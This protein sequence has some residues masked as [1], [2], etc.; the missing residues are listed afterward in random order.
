MNLV[1]SMIFRSR[2]TTAKGFVVE[3][4][5][6]VVLALSNV[7]SASECEPSVSVCCSLFHG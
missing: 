6:G 3:F 5:G 4:G 1:K 2:D 7:G